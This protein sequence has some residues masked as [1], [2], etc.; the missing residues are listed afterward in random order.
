MGVTGMWMYDCVCVVLCGCSLVRVYCSVGEMYVV[1][2]YC[3]KGVELL[4]GCYVDVRLCVCV[5]WASWIISSNVTPTG[6]NSTLFNLSCEL[7]FIKMARY[8]FIWT[9]F[10]PTISWHNYTFG[11]IFFRI[12]IK[13]A[14]VKICISTC[15][16]FDKGDTYFNTS[17]WGY[18]QGG[19]FTLI[20]LSIVCN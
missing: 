17:I 11:P 15:T 18:I 6:H 8:D 10:E 20:Y 7:G 12:V 1:W 13:V 5:V 9:L 2:M 14:T 16:D 19:L 3:T 4:Y